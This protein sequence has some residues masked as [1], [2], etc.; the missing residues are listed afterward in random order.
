MIDRLTNMVEERLVDWSNNHLSDSKNGQPFLPSKIVYY[1][2]GVGD[3]QYSQLLQKELPQIRAAYANVAK[4]LGLGVQFDLTAIV[5][6]KRHS[7]RFYPMNPQDRDR[8][9]P[10]AAIEANCVPGT[11]VDQDITSP[12]F[13][14][15]YLQ[16]HYGL[17]GTAKPTHYF[18]LCDENSFAVEDLQRMASS[19]F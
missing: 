14:D 1:R 6:A 5:V 12:Y 11:L 8:V 17:Q 2:D 15:F 19:L 10:R 4:R 9:G 13:K 3:S 16:S 18:V 7:T